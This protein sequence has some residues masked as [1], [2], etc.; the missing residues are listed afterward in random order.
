VN[1]VSCQFAGLVE[2]GGVRWHTLRNISSG[3]D[4]PLHN[5]KR[6]SHNFYGRFCNETLYFSQVEEALQ[7]LRK[8]RE[9]DLKFRIIAATLLS[10]TLPRSEEGRSW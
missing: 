5:E 1:S 9:N 4:T 6:G 8:K 10:E 3:Q 7:F 2:E